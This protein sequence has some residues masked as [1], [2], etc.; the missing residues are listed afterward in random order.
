MNRTRLAASDADGDF[1]ARV[2]LA[3]RPVSGSNPQAGCSVTMATT[4]C[5]ISGATRFLTMGLR[6]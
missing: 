4:A 2:E 3:G 1:P 5:L 6:W